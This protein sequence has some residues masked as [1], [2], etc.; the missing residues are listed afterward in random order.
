MISF[1]LSLWI[2][3][4]NKDAVNVPVQAHHHRAIRFLGAK[5]ENEWAF[6]NG[7]D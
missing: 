4:L 5:L 3:F 2:L 1:V 6:L 7:Y